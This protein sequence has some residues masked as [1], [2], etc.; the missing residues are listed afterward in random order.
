MKNT[1]SRDISQ[2]INKHLLHRHEN[3][4]NFFILSIGNIT[5]ILY[6]IILNWYEIDCNNLHIG[7][8]A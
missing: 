4:H 5:S 8:E 6:I 2:Q 3:N 7:K 1:T